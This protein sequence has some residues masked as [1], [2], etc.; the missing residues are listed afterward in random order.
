STL[1]EL[2]AL[3][4]I[5]RNVGDKVKG[6]VLHSTPRGGEIKTLYYRITDDDDAAD[7]EETAFLEVVEPN[8]YNELTNNKKWVLD[9]YTSREAAVE[10]VYIDNVVLKHYPNQAEPPSNITLEKVNNRNIKVDWDEQY[11]LNDIDI[12]NINNSER[13]YINFYKLLDGTPTQKW[14][15]SYRA[16]QGKLLELLQG[17]VVSQYQTPGN[18]LTGSL[19]CK[20]E[21]LPTT[22]L[23]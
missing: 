22:V 23:R 2:K 9:G 20:D 15:R 14:E 5:N 3:G 18:K 11:L 7:N 10:Y 8:D 16:G 19:L 21:I 13:T 12:E 1:P 4:T 6:K 17:E